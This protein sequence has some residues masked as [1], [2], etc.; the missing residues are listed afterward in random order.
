MSP[1]ISGQEVWNHCVKCWGCKW[2][3]WLIALD[4]INI[5]A[6]DYSGSDLLHWEMG[7]VRANR[8][9]RACLSAAMN[10]PVVSIHRC[11]CVNTHW[12]R[13]Q[14]G[15]SFHDCSLEGWG[16]GGYRWNTTT[17][18]MIERAQESRWSCDVWHH[19]NAHTVLWDVEC[20]LMHAGRP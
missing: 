20:D 19:R 8:Q 1:V 11:L 17:C 3:I 15:F 4:K 13:C 14:D 7:T 9:K 10:Q 5:S 2:G 12:A 16:V 18:G 6:K